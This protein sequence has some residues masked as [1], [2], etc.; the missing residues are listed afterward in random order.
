M[1]IL[2]RPLLIGIVLIVGTASVHAQ[3]PLKWG[4]DET[5]GAPYV[6]D[7]RRKG[8]EVELANLLA[9]ELGRTSEPVAG[10][11]N[12]LPELLAKGDIDV[13]LNG[14]EYSQHFREQASV[15]YY[16]YR[17]TLTVHKDSAIHSWDDLRKRKP[18]GSKHKVVVLTGSAALRYLQA[19]FKDDIELD[20]SDDVSTAYDLVAKKQDYDATVQDN[21]AAIFYVQTKNDERLRNI[22]ERRSDNFYVILTRPG[23]KQL[24]AQIDTALRNAIQNGTLEQIYRRYGLWNDDQERLWFWSQ[25]PWPPGLDQFSQTDQ[26][27][28]V[29]AGSVKWPEVLEMLGLAAS[30][31]I[32]LAIASFPIAILLGLLIAIAR[33]YGPVWL[34]IPCTAY[35]EIIRGTPLLLQ[36]FLLFYVLPTAFPGLH[37]APIVAG[38]IGLAIN[39]SA[40]EAENFRAGLQAIPKGQMEAALALGIS[41]LLTVRKIIVPQAVRIVIPPITNDFIALFKDT[42]VCSV[43]LITELSRQYN[44]L[45][46]NHRE[47]ILVFA[48]MTAAIYLLLSYPLSL[49][50]RYVER[51]FKKGKA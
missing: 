5:G 2:I 6:F 21:P 36:L 38:I 37:M 47:Y 43:I 4:M 31:T 3:Q 28:G 14:Y 33:L 35:V 18:D 15:P 20:S 17:L 11:W 13:V 49:L 48:A 16:I 26:G 51:R 10:D 23:D 41:P 50:A 34:R 1:A 42:S 27:K 7:Q 44:V 19:E 25:Q 30:R 32:L 12:K 29:D 46:N 45:Y 39:Y 9:K 22:G 40:Y 8:F 24:R